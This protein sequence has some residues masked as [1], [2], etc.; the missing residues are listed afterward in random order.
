[1]STENHYP[2]AHVKCSGNPKGPVALDTVSAW[3]CTHESWESE[4]EGETEI[5]TGR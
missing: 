1:M 5:E 4:L 3:E 2:S